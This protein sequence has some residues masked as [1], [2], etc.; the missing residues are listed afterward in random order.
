MT[1]ST[2]EESQ[3]EG[4][5]ITL[6]AFTWDDGVPHQLLYTDGEQPQTYPSLGISSAFTPIPIQRGS[7][8]T[9]GTLDK[10]SLE[11]NVPR[12]AAIALLFR[13]YP[14]GQ[15]VNVT[16][17]QTHSGDTEKQC[18][19]IWAGRVISCAI[20]FNMAQLFCEPISTSLRRNGLRLNYQKTC[21]YDLYGQG[22]FASK[23]AATISDA[24]V[25][26]VGTNDF[27][28]ISSWLSDPSKR[29]AYVTGM[30]EWHDVSGVRHVRSI[31]KI[32]TGEQVFLSGPVTG[33]VPGNTVKMTL[34]CNRQR[35]HCA[36]LH[37]NI[38]NFGGQPFIPVKTPF[39][40]TS[41]YY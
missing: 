14:P 21:P 15:V 38:D 18:L 32:T 31:L 11:I 39:G 28:L 22:C 13:D 24:V 27:T 25:A 37:N 35:S 26:A 34:G 7:I 19:V 23:E 12:D 10:S 2:M 17:W 40:F 4:S 8:S 20:E 3:Y 5:P 30:V 9:Q 6:Y 33:L 29:S 1:F 41:Q 36:D 16:I